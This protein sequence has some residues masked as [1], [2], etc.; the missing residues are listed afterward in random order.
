MRLT[1]KSA[2]AV[3]PSAWASASMDSQASL[4]SLAVMPHH[5]L[6]SIMGFR[7]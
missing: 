6:P 3:G 2:T 5:L 4:K 7:S 1:A